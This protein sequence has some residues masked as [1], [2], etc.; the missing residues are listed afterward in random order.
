MVREKC[1]ILRIYHY[2]NVFPTRRNNRQPQKWNWRICSQTKMICVL[3]LTN[4]VLQVLRNAE[5]RCLALRTTLEKQ[6]YAFE[7]ACAFIVTWPFHQYTTAAAFWFHYMSPLCYCSLT[8]L[9]VV[10]RVVRL[11]RNLHHLHTLGVR[12]R[13]F[14]LQR[15]LL[16]IKVAVCRRSKVL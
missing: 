3:S 16:H 5:F 7:N 15:L 10:C 11:W 4:F 14:P 6:L 12:I 1:V 9:A 2:A 8:H 13:M